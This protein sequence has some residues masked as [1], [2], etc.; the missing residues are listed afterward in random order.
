MHCTSAVTIG[1]KDNVY[2]MYRYGNRG[3]VPRSHA[4]Y[5]SD[6]EKRSAQCTEVKEMLT[7]Q[8]R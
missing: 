7:L 6:D 2:T 8:E 4:V 1:D 3:L 5:N